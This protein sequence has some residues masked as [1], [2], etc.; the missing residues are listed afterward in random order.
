M[1]QSVDVPFIREDDT[2]LIFSSMYWISGL[3]FLIGSVIKGYCR[4]ITTERVTPELML[5]MVEE[6]RVR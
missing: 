3:L 2:L 1:Q 6:H 4:V 5:N